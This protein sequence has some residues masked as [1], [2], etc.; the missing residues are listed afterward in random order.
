MSETLEEFYSKLIE[1]KSPWQV[2]CVQRDSDTR[3]ITVVVKTRD[4]IKLSCPVCGV[5]SKLHDH[6]T[7]RWRHLDSC[8]HKTIVEAA[9]PRVKCS[10]H[11]VKQINVTW[12]ERNSRFTL[13]LES[14]VLMWLRSDSI[15]TVAKNFGLTWDEVDGIMCRAVKRGLKRRQKSKPTDIGID[16]TSYRKRHEYVTVIYDKNNNA[17]VDVLDDRKQSTLSAW[18]ARQDRADLSEVMSISMDM[19]NPYIRATAE[20]F[21]KWKLI[22]AFDRFH[23]A[24]YLGRAVDKV[25]AQE[26][27]KF[28]AALGYSPLSHSK[29]QW[30]KTSSKTDNRTKSRREFMKLSKQNLKTARAWRIKEAAH[31]A[32]QYVNVKIAEAKWK[33]LIRWMSLSRLTPMIKVGKMIRTHLW[34]ILNAI[35]LGVN[36][37]ELESCNS[38]IQRVKKIACGFR[39]KERFKNAI[40]FHLGGL[41]MKPVPTL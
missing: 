13:E 1:I 35:R 30:L 17:V 3:E 22:T 40:L 26:H 36:N 4:K 41:D 24:Q 28:L 12:A 38:R 39:N 27:K 2:S 25:R 15:S 32:W 9:I 18:Y 7:R 20:N 19:W 21:A 8:N 33:E 37:S 10:E 16:E 29:M 6:K 23:I 11:G 5:T 31:L 34:G 14:V